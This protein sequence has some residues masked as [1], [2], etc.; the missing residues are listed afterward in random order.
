MSVIGYA[1]K[2]RL[3]NTDSGAFLGFGN[4]AAG[5]EATF[6]MPQAVPGMQ[7]MVP[8]KQA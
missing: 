8:L 6:L 4:R 2:K 5:P 3:L 1:Y 7:P